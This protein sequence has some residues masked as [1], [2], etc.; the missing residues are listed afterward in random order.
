MKKLLIFISCLVLGPVLGCF[1]SDTWHE[2]ANTFWK[3]IDYFPYPVKNLIITRQQG[4]EIWIET[5]E[6]DTYQITY[7]CS[8]NQTC[9]MQKDN[10]P[11]DLPEEPYIIYKVGK[12]KCENDNIFYPLLS[13]IE[14]CI[15]SIDHAA[16]ATWTTSVALT[17]NNKLWIWDQPYEDPFSVI[18]NMFSVVIVSTIIGFFTGIFFLVFNPKKRKGKRK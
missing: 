11:P 18:I 16:D 14:K 17:T 7:P 3:Q 13:K 9:W 2:G 12:N 1:L 4:R 15:T 5:T 10:I 6:N 8:K